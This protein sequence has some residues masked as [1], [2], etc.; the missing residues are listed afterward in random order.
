MEELEK[1]SRSANQENTMLRAQVER[2][3]AEVREYRKR[4]SWISRESSFSALS[5]LQSVNTRN[6]S[7]LNNDFVFDFPRFGELSTNQI[8]SNGTGIKP[9][10]RAQSISNDSS[11]SV[12]ASASP[13]SR[14]HNNTLANGHHQNSVDSSFVGGYH[15]QTGTSS[16]SA[17]NTGSPS[18]SS[19]S[20]N[21]HISSQ[22]TSPEPAYSPP[23]TNGTE[24]EQRSDYC[25]KIDGK[26]FCEKLNMACGNVRD[27]VPAILK[28]SHSARPSVS[29]GHQRSQSQLPTSPTSP[30]TSQA[31]TSTSTP[32]QTQSLVDPTF[33]LDWLTQQ[34]GGNF[35]PVLFND[36]RE[37]QD[38]VLSQDFGNFFDDVFPFP[39]LTGSPFSN[40]N[41]DYS[42]QT[43][44]QGQGQ[45]HKK[46]LVAEID[47]KLDEDEEVV[48]GED[49]SE[50]LTCTKIW[51][52]VLYFYSTITPV[53]D[54]PHRDRLQSN[55][56]F[57]N[58]EIDVDSLCSELRTKA[59]CSEEGVVIKEKDVEEVMGWAGI[60][61]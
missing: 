50:M 51:Y 34:N 27:P 24:N 20:Q 55:E 14:D 33:S 35:D 44:T 36:Y 45:A 56:K 7:G 17:S 22:G 25:G 32:G 2:L 52:V 4:L 29:D 8:S 11:S 58:G 21:A 47:K 38:A 3:Q 41:V 42:A 46:D 9:T 40:S 60:T 30:A 31:Q 53:T 1:V 61:R 59:R 16:Y 54:I 49:A 23:K 5:A 48:P 12:R 26:S 18:T 10:A 39:D 13:S 37:P 28:K 15:H 43:Q 6:L 19:E 57:R